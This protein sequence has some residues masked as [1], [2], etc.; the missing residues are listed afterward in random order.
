[1]KL[2]LLLALS[3]GIIASSSGMIQTHAAL[4][5]YNVNFSTKEVANFNDFRPTYSIDTYDLTA[6]IITRFAGTYSFNTCPTVFTVNVTYNAYARLNG[7]GTTYDLG[8]TSLPDFV[9]STTPQTYSAT[10][11]T[12]MN[13]LIVGNIMKDDGNY[14]RFYGDLFFAQTAATNGVIMALSN[15]EVSYTLEYD[16]DTTY[17]FNYFLSDTRFANGFRSGSWNKRSDSVTNVDYVFTTAG[18]DEYR[19]INTDVLNNLGNIRKKY[20]VNYNDVYFR[21]TS[22]GAKIAR[23]YPTNAPFNTDLLTMAASGTAVITDQYDYYFLNT[24]NF[25]QEI[26]DAPTFSFTEEDCGSFL[27]LNVGCFVNNAFAY[28]TNDAPIIS[29]AFTLL[30]SGIGMA[31]QTF[32]IIGAFADDNVFGVLILAGFGFIAIKWFLKN[33]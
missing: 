20:A 13:S 2:N 10:V 25:S 15:Y 16:F 31:A 32:G 19:I 4:Y 33:D 26:V 14:S 11:T 27:A 29:D 18:N 23:R 24:S 28:I 1:M 22:V 30:N 12:P 9:C 17:L 8:I 6:S 7:A 21:G 5:T 3:F